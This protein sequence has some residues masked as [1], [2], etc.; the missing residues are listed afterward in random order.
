VK[1]LELSLKAFGP[2]TDLSLDLGDIDNGIHVLYGQNEAGKSTTLRAVMGLL[3]GISNKTKDAHSHSMPKLRIGAQIVSEDGRQLSFTRRKGLRNTVLDSAEKPLPDDALRSFLGTVNAELFQTVFGLSHETL[4]AGGMAL[5]EGRGAVG[6][7]LFGAGLGGSHIHRLLLQLNEH[8]DKIYS[9]RASKKPVNKALSDLKKARQSIREHSLPASQWLE[10]QNELESAQT[11]RKTFSDQLRGLEKDIYRLERF[12]RL[13]PALAKR[14][15]ILLEINELGD[16]PALPRDSQDFRQRAQQTI[17]EALPRENRINAELLELHTK[18]QTL[19]G[20]EALVSEHVLMTDLNQKLGSLV[21][22]DKDM[23]RVWGETRLVEDDIVRIIRELGSECL[24]E[25]VESLRLEAGCEARILSL[26]LKET[27]LTERLHSAQKKQSEASHDIEHSEKELQ[28]IAA[29]GDLAPLKRALGAAQQEGQLDRLIHDARDAHRR[30]ETER[31]RLFAKLRLSLPIQDARSLKTPSAELLQS[32]ADK[33]QRLD[34]QR[35]QIA[36]QQRDI[37][38]QLSAVDKNL[39]QLSLV[40]DVP[41]EAAL[42]EARAVRNQNWQAVLQNIADTDPS[43]PALEALDNT[44]CQYQDLVLDADDLSDRLRREADRVAQLAR[45]LAENQ[46]LGLDQ[47]RIRDAIED[48]EQEQAR[49]NKNWLKQWDSQISDS[50]TALEMRSWLGSYHRFLEIDEQISCSKAAALTLEMRRSDCVNELA[51]SLA[52]LKARPLEDGLSLA[53]ALDAANNI[54]QSLSALTQKRQDLAGFIES[55]KTLKRQL[56]LA[57]AEHKGA[58]DSWRQEWTLAMQLLRLG[59]DTGPDEASAVLEKYRQLFRKQ[60]ERTRLLRRYR[61]MNNDQKRFTELVSGLVETF[62]PEYLDRPTLQAA[63]ELIDRFHKGRED[64]TLGIELTRQIEEKQAALKELQD[65]HQGAQESLDSLLDV[66]R[67]EDL[68]DLEQ[69]EQKNLR[70]GE[71]RQQLSIQEEHLLNLGDGAIV[72]ELIE[73]VAAIDAASLPGQIESLRERCQDIMKERS[74]IDEAIGSQREKLNT[75]DGQSK[76]AE[77]ALMVEDAKARIQS[78]LHQFI[79]HRLA[80]RVLK[81]EIE[82]YRERH[83]GPVLKRARVL[84]QRM[85]LNSFAD[86]KVGFDERD[87]PILRCVRPS[88]EELE[89]GGLSAGTRD[90]LYLALRIASLERY[91][92]NHEALPFICDDIL[93]HFDDDR[94]RACLKILGELSEKT[95]ILFFTH[96]KRLV[97]LATE[98]IPAVRLRTHKLSKRSVENSV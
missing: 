31:D 2:F 21:K 95:Q 24:L 33:E 20:S 23:P 78:G 41:T 86:M 64:R 53:Q 58:L 9:G 30:L 26:A 93:I 77:S 57:L 27:G 98:C 45:L 69:L 19:S 8:A 37:Q 55:T 68:K 96:H 74:V 66:T 63:R 36:G 52:P 84:F 76:A 61:G 97:D 10:T 15:Q 12:Q 47:S 4:Q 60:D 1:F 34:N 54:D 73:E 17:R 42:K 7:S 13:L 67:C 82:A 32:F 50:G 71:L 83:Q 65:K 62:A 11:R 16:L 5:L 14:R 29:V 25:D 89:T 75:M 59:P 90:Q 22:A 91:L 88:G 40:G 43:K 72:S 38:R 79:R 85:T 51:R 80:E 92:E 56:D 39:N 46:S 48:L 70:L 81:S 35:Q 3:Y 49:L 18:C 87:N 6:E 28:S 44:L 94:A